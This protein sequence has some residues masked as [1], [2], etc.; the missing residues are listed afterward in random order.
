TSSVAD[1]HLSGV[2]Y[3]SDDPVK[4]YSLMVIQSRS[5]MM[6]T[7]RG[8]FGFMAEEGSISNAVKT[9]S[10]LENNGRTSFE[11]GGTAK[12]LNERPYAFDMK[13]AYAG[14]VNNGTGSLDGFCLLVPS[15][16][17]VVNKVAFDAEMFLTGNRFIRGYYGQ[18]Y[19]DMQ[20]SLHLD[21]NGVVDSSHALSQKVNKVLYTTGTRVAM[22]ISPVRGAS[23][24][25]EWEKVL[26]HHSRVLQNPFDPSKDD[27]ASY[28]PIEAVKRVPGRNDGA[29]EIRAQ[30]GNG[31]ILPSLLWFDAFYRI[32]RIGYFE[33][34]RFDPFSPNPF[35]LAGAELKLRLRK[36]M[37]ISAVWEHFYYDRNGSFTIE[38]GEK[39]DAFRAGVHVG[40]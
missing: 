3:F 28:E 31:F 8:D 32:E 7:A 26:T 15:F 19:E 23:L 20:Y 39:V 5:E 37:D 30:I 29:F 25:V 40:F 27:L 1:F 21:N 2:H 16:T 18:M 14:V 13:L 11:I 34:G 35:T 33:D 10:T 36:N 22:R 12:L 17:A 9:D 6:N 4:R 38:E 24:A